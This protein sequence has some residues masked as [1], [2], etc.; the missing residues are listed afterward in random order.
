MDE[1]QALSEL[2][3]G[4]HAVGVD[5][6]AEEDHEVLSREVVDVVCGVLVDTIHDELSDVV[7]TGSGTSAVLEAGSTQ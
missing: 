4:P 6:A 1:D 7:H 2:Q 3:E 5:H